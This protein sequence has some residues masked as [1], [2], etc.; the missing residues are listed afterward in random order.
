MIPNTQEA[1]GMMSANTPE[2]RQDSGTDTAVKNYFKFVNQ[3]Y[4]KD[5]SSYDALENMEI[6]PG[7]PE[8]NGM[9]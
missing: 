4:K 2:I 8:L 5:R 7:V 9:L 3:D 1:A 6:K